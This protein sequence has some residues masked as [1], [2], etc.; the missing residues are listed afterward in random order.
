MTRHGLLEDALVSYADL[1]PTLKLKWNSGVNNYMVYA[2]GD[3]PTG[4]YNPDRLANIGIGHGALD[5][6][7]G[8]AS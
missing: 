4:D 2:A 7:A 6:G 8:Y 3:V 5:V 1:Y